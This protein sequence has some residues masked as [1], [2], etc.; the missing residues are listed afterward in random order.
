MTNTMLW[1]KAS[2]NYA[3]MYAHDIY[4]TERARGASM[5]FQMSF[6]VVVNTTTKIYVKIYSQM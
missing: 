1:S 3:Q 2:V 6:F 4:M 5:M